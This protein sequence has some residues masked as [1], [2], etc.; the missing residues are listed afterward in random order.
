MGSRIVRSYAVDLLCDGAPQR[1]Q[2]PVDLAIETV[3]DADEVKVVQ[4]WHIARGNHITGTLLDSILMAWGKFCHESRGYSERDPIVRIT[5][6]SGSIYRNI[7]FSTIDLVARH[8]S[9][10]DITMGVL[11]E[12]CS[13]PGDHNVIDDDTLIASIFAASGRQAMEVW[14]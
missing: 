11:H 3:D 10:T 1:L 9:G 4:A 2:R 13:H 6:R 7:T 5:L 8:H 14:P 12:I